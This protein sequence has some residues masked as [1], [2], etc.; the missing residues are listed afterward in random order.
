MSAPILPVDTLPGSSPR[1]WLDRTGRSKAPRSAPRPHVM[2]VADSLVAPVTAT[3]AGDGS[4]RL[5]VVDQTG[6]IRI[7]K[8]GALLATPFLDLPGEIP[9]L[10][11]GFDER[12]LLGLAFHPDYTNNGRL[13]VRYS[14][15]RDT[16]PVGP[17][18][19]TNRGCHEEVLAEFSV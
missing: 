8:N 5:F 18:T 12:G 7:I 13:F 3:H 6:Q 16:G 11:P 14:H 10:D 19:G 2:L 4:E 9:A 15:P 1:V 17:C